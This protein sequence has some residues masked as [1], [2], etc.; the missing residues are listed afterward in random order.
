MHVIDFSDHIGKETHEKNMNYSQIIFEKWQV[1]NRGIMIQRI[2]GTSFLRN[3]FSIHLF[4][5]IIVQIQPGLFLFLIL[6]K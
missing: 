4:F 3:H 1:L 5:P 6:F 2:L